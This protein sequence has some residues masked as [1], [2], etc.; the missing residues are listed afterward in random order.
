M[1]GLRRIC[2]GT[3]VMLAAL[4]VAAPASYGNIQPPPELL[5]R[6]WPLF[7]S[8]R[9][10][11]LKPAEPSPA[12][13]EPT[14]PLIAPYVPRKVDINSASFFQIQSLPGI[15]SSMA[16]HIFAGRPYRNLQDLERDGIPLNVVRDLADKVEFGP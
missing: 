4:W 5:L 6:L 14:R 3:I 11:P 8:H 15:N 13:S 1:P 2:G 9:P 10:T 12:P 16:A 7:R